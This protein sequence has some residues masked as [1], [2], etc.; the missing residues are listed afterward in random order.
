MEGDCGFPRNWDCLHIVFVTDGMS[1]GPLNA[2]E[3]ANR[4]RATVADVTTHSIG[5]G[6]VNQ[7]ELRCLASDPDERFVLYFDNFDQFVRDMETLYGV[8]QLESALSDASTFSCVNFSH[9]FGTS[10]CPL[11][12]EQC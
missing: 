5:I 11:Q 8:L 10:S 3:E 7:D 1:N 4:L 2:C 12:R 6:N 9:R